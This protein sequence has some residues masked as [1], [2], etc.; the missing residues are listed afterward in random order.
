MLPNSYAKNDERGENPVREEKK[1]EEAWICWPATTS[2]VSG[3]L[4]Q[5]R[6]WIGEGETR[7]VQ[8]GNDAVAIFVA[9]A[10]LVRV[11][12]VQLHSPFT[13]TQYAYHEWGPIPGSERNL[14]IEE[15]CSGVPLG[16]KSSGNKTEEGTLASGRI[17]EEVMN[18][19]KGYTV[20]Q[21]R[22][23]ENWK[24]SFSQLASLANDAIK[25]VPKILADVESAL[26]IFNPPKKVEAFLNYCKKLMREMK[27]VMAETR[28]S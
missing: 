24:R 21:E 10:G 18:Q 20:E 28:D 25:D 4:K 9:V 11:W 17:K 23:T 13:H 14:E 19:T 2:V 22:V 16:C 7:L 12:G 15:L 26:P 27:N 3:G 8:R 5:R 6:D 1:G